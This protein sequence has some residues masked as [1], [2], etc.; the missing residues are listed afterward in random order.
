M[1]PVVKE[2]CDHASN[3]VVAQGFASRNLNASAATSPSDASP[4]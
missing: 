1:W 3:E 2:L 4:L